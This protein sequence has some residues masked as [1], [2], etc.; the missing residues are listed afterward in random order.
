MDRS[1]RERLTKAVEQA[2]RE[3]DAATTRTTINAAAAKLQRAR[4][5]LK[6]LDAAPSERPKRR[7]RQSPPKPQKS[8]SRSASRQSPAFPGRGALPDYYRSIRGASFA[9]DAQSETQWQCQAAPGYEAPSHPGARH[10][11]CQAESGHES[12]YVRFPAVSAASPSAAD[13]RSGGLEGS[14]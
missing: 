11:P 10:G 2:E 6:R 8:Y 3:L 12:R 7:S 5:E 1:R 13:I 9:M 4:A 14:T